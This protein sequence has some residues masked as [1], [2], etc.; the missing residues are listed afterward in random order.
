MQRTRTDPA[1]HEPAGVRLVLG[2]G[3]DRF[4]RLD[5]FV[6]VIDRDVPFQHPRQ[7]VYAKDKPA[8]G[9]AFALAPQL[10]RR[11][12][13]T[14]NSTHRE[15]VPRGIVPELPIDEARAMG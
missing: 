1:E 12:K 4:S 10:R 7:R 11:E 3:F 6:Y 8:F 9:Q 14:T 5:D 13:C 15:N 2:I